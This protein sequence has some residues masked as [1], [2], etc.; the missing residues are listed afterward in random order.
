MEDAAGKDSWGTEEGVT[1]VAQAYYLSADTVLLVTE[2][3]RCEGGCGEFG[4]RGCVEV[5]PAGAAEE[6]DVAKLEG[7]GV[8][9]TV[10]IFTG[11]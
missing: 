7:R 8:G 6:L 11:A 10:G 4:V 3:E 5:Q 1:T 2:G 9:W